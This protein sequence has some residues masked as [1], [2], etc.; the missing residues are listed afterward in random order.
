MPAVQHVRS[1]WS[2]SLQFVDG[3]GGELLALG[4]L[5]EGRRAGSLVV[6]SACRWTCECYGRYFLAGLTSSWQRGFLAAAW[7]S[8]PWASPRPRRTAPRRSA[9]SSCFIITMPFLP[10]G[11]EPRT[12]SSPSSSMIC[13]SGH[14]FHRG[15]LHVRPG[16]RSCACPCGRGRGSD[17]TRWSRRGGR[18]RGYRGCCARPDMWWRFMTP[19]KPLPLVVPH[20]VDERAGLEHRA[21]AGTG[22][23]TSKV[24][25]LIGRSQPELADEARGG[26][27]CSAC[28]RCPA[29]AL[30]ARRSGLLAVADAHRGVTV[31]VRGAVAHHHAIACVND[32]DTGA[33]TLSP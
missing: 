9:W 8:W 22:L 21:T 24:L 33:I 32:G 2:I 23:P 7:P 14:A 11:T 4:P 1:R 20:D 16:G 18:I 30:L 6:A 29:P 15:R 17:G 26:T 13:T 31:L 10:P 25:E 3:A 12:S 5:V 19:W 27:L 28:W